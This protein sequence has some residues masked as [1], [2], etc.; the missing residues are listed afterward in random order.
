M[1]KNIQLLKKCKLFE[2]LKDEQIQ[3]VIEYLSPKLKDYAKGEFLFTAGTQL[4]SIGIVICGNVQIIK[5][6]ISG[7][8]LILANIQPGDMFGEGFVYSG[9][10]VTVSAQAAQSTTVMLISGNS[11]TS[12]CASPYGIILTANLLSTFA[13]KNIFLTVRIE[14]LTKRTL[15]DKIMSYLNDCA[16]KNQSNTFKIPFNRQEMADYLA[17]DRSALSSV[18]SKLKKDGYI[19]FQ[20]NNFTVK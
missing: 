3:A 17:A 14:H 16:L 10:A 5:E 9:E 15:A 7:N 13:R 20:K 4:K 12:A 19:D 6:D 8:S 18:L 1:K 2:G 11:I